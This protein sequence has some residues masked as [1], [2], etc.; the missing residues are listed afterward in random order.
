[1]KTM[2]C[3]ECGS[4][5]TVMNDVASV[6]CSLCVGASAVGVVAPSATTPK[7]ADGSYAVPVGKEVKQEAKKVEEEKPERKKRQRRDSAKLMYQIGEARSE[8]EQPKRGKK[9]V[10]GVMILEH[11][12][13]HETASFDELL[14]VYKEGK[15]AGGKKQIMNF[16]ALMY[17]MEKSGKVR[18]IA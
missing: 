12:K 15:S 6:R 9:S 16:R 13:Q 10:Y 2:E 8:A 7:R 11:L 17:S 14:A 18:V 5:V 4:I 1:M 3:S